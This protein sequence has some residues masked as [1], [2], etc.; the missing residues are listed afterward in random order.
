MPDDT[1]DKIAEQARAFL[2][3]AKPQ[4]QD[5]IFLYG[6]LRELKK[7]IARLLYA[8]ARR[9]SDDAPDAH[10][11]AARLWAFFSNIDP[12]KQPEG[13]RQFIDSFSGGEPT[14]RT[15]HWLSRA[16]C[17]SVGPP[18]S[19]DPVPWKAAVEHGFA[20]R[21]AVAELLQ[22]VRG[23]AAGHE[24]GIGSAAKLSV[25]RPRAGAA[26]MR[27]IEDDPEA[28]AAL[29][30]AQARLRAFAEAMKD[31]D[32]Q[33][34]HEH[35]RREQEQAL[36]ALADA[37]QESARAA[38]QDLGD[39][40]FMPPM[41]LEDWEHLA[42]VV[43]MP[44]E[45]IQAGNFT[46]RDVYVMALAWVDRQRMKSQLAEETNG[47]PQPRT[48]SGARTDA[49]HPAVSD[50]SHLSA[51][52]LAEVFDLPAD[53]LRTRLNR[54]RVN[55]HTGWI[56]NPERGPRE[57]KYLYRVGSVRHVI[58][59]MRAT[60]ETTSERPAKKK[61]C[62]ELRQLAHFPRPANNR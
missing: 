6:A 13:Q 22:A 57:A 54:W 42:R 60:S 30:R 48:D 59:A 37:I 11:D 56:E 49:G 36:K 58:D 34:E 28:Q 21:A 45:T 35:A 39:L 46:A 7:R 38:Q 15:L 8:L 4:I 52:K 12:R 3:W 10:G 17:L 53:A 18:R 19:I 27:A 47:K 62:D 14:D 5:G 50:D 44:F 26:F 29:H 61:R 1:M 43:E 24:A 25:E 16:D 33:R 51:A 41:T 32:F 40:G 9:S 23:V 31:P 55:N 20:G 2:T